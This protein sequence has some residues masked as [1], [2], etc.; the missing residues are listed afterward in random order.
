MKGYDLCLDSSRF[1]REQIL[2]IL[3]ALYNTI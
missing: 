3:V 2:E 1:T